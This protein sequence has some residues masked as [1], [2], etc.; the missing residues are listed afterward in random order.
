MGR[1]GH[2][3]FEV[4]LLVTPELE[5]AR[6]QLVAALLP[7]CALAY[8]AIPDKYANNAELRAVKWMGELANPFESF[9][10]ARFDCIRDPST[11]H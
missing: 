2:D 10:E 1:A 6:L 5:M 3:F 4:R 8:Q 11:D 9:P 7:L